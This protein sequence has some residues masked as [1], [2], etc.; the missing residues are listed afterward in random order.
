MKKFALTFMLVL[1]FAASSV[2]APG[3][4]LVDR[5]KAIW[6]IATMATT[7][8]PDGIL[9]NLLDKMAA[10]PDSYTAEAD[11]QEWANWMKFDI[12]LAFGGKIFN[13]EV[14]SAILYAVEGYNY[15][16]PRI[17]ANR[18]AP[19]CEVSGTSIVCEEDP[20]AE[21][22]S[23]LLWR[24]VN[25]DFVEQELTGV[26]ADGTW[27][28]SPIPSGIGNLVLNYDDGLA[29]FPTLFLAIP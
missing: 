11:Q 23:I 13:R 1:S 10:I 21:A 19:V 9:Q 25:G 27:T 26:L 5:N 22:R 20:T 6:L 12:S 24:F 15:G 2:A 8:Y 3:D 28:F 17:S 16:D 18:A 14:Y 7:D 29:S 4:V